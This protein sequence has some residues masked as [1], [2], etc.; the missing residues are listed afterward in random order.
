MYH[1]LKGMFLNLF[2]KPLLN[3]AI[4]IVMMGFTLFMAALEWLKG[5]VPVALTL[6]IS[7]LSCISGIIYWILVWQANRKQV[8]SL[9]CQ[10]L[11][12]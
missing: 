2:R 4:N 11:A 8:S 9:S 6:T 12:P 3:L 7:G 5:N 10:H 1:I